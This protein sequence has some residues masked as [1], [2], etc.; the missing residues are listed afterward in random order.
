MRQAEVAGLASTR[1]SSATSAA[2]KAASLR[3]ISS[4]AGSPR[5]WSRCHTRTPVSSQWPELP[6][7]EC[8]SFRGAPASLRARVIV[9]SPAGL[10]SA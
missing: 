5:N 8:Q 1:A 2:V 10:M 3:R 7:L 4:G 9:S 6:G